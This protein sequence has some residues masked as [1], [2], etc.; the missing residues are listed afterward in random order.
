VDLTGVAGFDE[1]AFVADLHSY[2]ELVIAAGSA[3]DARPAIWVSPDAGLS[4]TSVV[5][6]SEDPGMGRFEAS[7]VVDTGDGLLVVGFFD[8]TG[9]FDTFQV[10]MWRHG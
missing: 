2:Q 7:H 6:P 9:G 4:W 5:L 1:G 8:P 10:Q 3:P